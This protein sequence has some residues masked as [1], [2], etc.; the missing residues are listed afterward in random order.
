MF[1]KQKD[2]S[3]SP[4]SSST[5]AATVDEIVDATVITTMIQIKIINAKNANKNPSGVIISSPISQYCDYYSIPKN[6]SQE[7]NILF[8]MLFYIH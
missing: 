6:K 3:S 8:P 7:Y 2:Y 5:T 4:S 1:V